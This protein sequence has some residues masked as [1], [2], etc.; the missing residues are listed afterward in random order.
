MIGL[1]KIVSKSYQ[2]VTKEKNLEN[3]NLVS[4]FAGYLINDDNTYHLC[5]GRTKSSSVKKCYL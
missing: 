2:P 3:P 4:P 5:G 1:T